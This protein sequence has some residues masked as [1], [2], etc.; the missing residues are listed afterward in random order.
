MSKCWHTIWCLQL[1]I[2]HD[3][4]PQALNQTNDSIDS[5]PLSE[6]SYLYWIYVSMWAS[7]QHISN[8]L[9]SDA[10]KPI[11]WDDNYGFYDRWTLFTILGAITIEKRFPMV[12]PSFNSLIISIRTEVHF[13]FCATL[14]T[15]VSLNWT[16]DF[17]PHRISKKMISDL[18]INMSR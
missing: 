10:R 2:W 9:V 5:K 14:S 6:S 15:I 13:S 1:D 12:S 18:R 3:A 17:Q 11:P 7:L 16:F 4:T 8:L